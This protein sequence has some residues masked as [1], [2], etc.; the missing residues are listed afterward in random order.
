[1]VNAGVDKAYRDIIL[2]HSLKGMDV[3]Y[4]TPSEAD[5]T[6]AMGKYTRYIDQNLEVKSEISD[7][8][9]DQVRV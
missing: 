5:L 8:L 1:M 2:G 3:H 9:S 6:D 7:H 4:I